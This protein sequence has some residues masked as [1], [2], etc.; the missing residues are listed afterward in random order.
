M[1]KKADYLEIVRRAQL[2]DHES[3][4]RLAQL[5]Q[6]RVFVYI[7]RLT[8][9]Y[10]LSQDLTQETILEMIRSLKKL[11]HTNSFWSWLF[12]TAL[13]KVQHHFRNQGPRRIAKQTIVNTTKVLEHAPKDYQTGL[14]SLVRKESKQLILEAMGRI[15]FTYRNVLTLRCFEQMSYSEIASLLGCTNI[16]AQL[17]FFRAKRS[18]KKQLS[19]QGFGKEHFLNALALFGAIT[20]VADKP[21][22]T[23]A[24]ISAASTEVGFIATVVGSATTGLGAAAV[25]GLAAAVLAV[26]Q[27][28]VF[29]KGEQ[30]SSTPTAG[31][32]DMQAVRSFEYPSSMV[33]VHDPDADGWKGSSYIRQRVRAVPVVPDRLLVGRHP[34]DT[35][36]VILPKDHWVELEF[37]GTIIDGRG[38]DICTDGRVNGGQPRIF[39]TDAA[40]QEYELAEPY[41]QRYFGN[42][43]ALTGYDIAGVPIFFEPRGVRIVG[44]GRTDTQFGFELY[45][46]VARVAK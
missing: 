22:S 16:Q 31:R 9:S 28:G 14:T 20:A 13:G 34:P 32:L 43:F 42:G 11:K 27:I 40:G 23:A 35:I 38:A 12:R 37:P 18:L 17:L 29:E 3:M 10:D 33:N 4:S 41:G 26:A 45:T 25:I 7:Y 8:L 6:G 5:A 1:S 36:S 24:A 39:I 2:G 15:K 21:A 46:V 44:T 30:T 19:R